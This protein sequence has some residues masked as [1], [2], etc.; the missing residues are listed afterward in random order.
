M[1]GTYTRLQ[2]AVLDAQDA[3]AL[4]EQVKGIRAF[5]ALGQERLQQLHDLLGNLQAQ[6]YPADQH[7]AALRERIVHMILTG[8]PYE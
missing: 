4:V 8:E 6:L 5:F 2:K 7:L 3:L 1:I